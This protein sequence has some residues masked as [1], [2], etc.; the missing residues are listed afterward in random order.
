MP[1]LQAMIECSVWTGVEKIF[2]LSFVFQ[3]LNAYGFFHD[4]PD[5]RLGLHHLFLIDAYLREGKGRTR[6]FD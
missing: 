4:V 6:N 5:Y 1:E 3:L 2:L